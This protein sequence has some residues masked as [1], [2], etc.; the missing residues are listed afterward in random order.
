[1]DFMT[2][3][4]TVCKTAMRTSPGLMLLKGG[5]VMGKWSYAN[6]PNWEQLKLDLKDNVEGLFPSVPENVP[7]IEA[8]NIQ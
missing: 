5:N 8:D 1:M 3:D 6:Y 7:V 4:G 2:I